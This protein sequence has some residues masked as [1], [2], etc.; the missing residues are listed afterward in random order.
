MT[1]WDWAKSAYARPGVEASCLSLQDDHDQSVCLLLWAAWRGPVDADTREAAADA[2][3]SWHTHAI[4]PVRALR[5]PLK[6][7]L[8]DMDDARRMA[9]HDAT[10]S[11]ELQAERGLLE[12][13][14]AIS[15]PPDGGAFAVVDSL[16]AV[17]RLWG[18]RTPREALKTLAGRLPEPGT[19]DV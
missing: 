18:D 5:R 6:K 12:E 15:G 13:L 4:D 19:G 10:L 17:S 3:R 1:L 8:S 11:L 2:A 9:L 7:P 16:A 14:E